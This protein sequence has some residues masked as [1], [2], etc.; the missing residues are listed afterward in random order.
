MKNKLTKKL[1]SAVLS[2]AMLLSLVP[3]ASLTAWADNAAVTYLDADGN[4][5][6][7]TE[8]TVFDSSM[9]MI[10]EAGWYVV[11]ENVPISGEMYISADVNLILCD[12]ATL[13]VT[14]ETYGG[15]VNG[16]KNLTIYAQSTG[17]DM[18]G[19]SVTN[20]QSYGYALDFSDG[21]IIINGGKISATGGIS[22]YNGD[23][24]I[25]GG[26]VTAAG[27]YTNGICASTNNNLTINGGTVTVST[28]DNS[29]GGIE[30][31]GNVIVNGG[32]VSAIG[33][34]NS[35][36]CSTGVTVS[37]GALTVATTM[38]GTYGIN[39]ENKGDVT[40]SGGELTASAP[41][42][43]IAYANV[44]NAVPG[45][46]WTD[47][48]GTSGETEIAVSTTGQD[49]SAYKKVVIGTPAPEPVSYKNAAYD[50][51]TNTVTY[52]DATCD[53]YTAVAATTTEWGASG[54]TS[55]YVVNDTVEITSSITVSGTVN[56]ILCDGAS[57]T[58]S[59]GVNAS[60]ATLNIYGQSAGTGALIANAANGSDGDDDS[61]GG[62]G[63]TA[64][65]CGTL[66]VNGAAVTATGGNG[67]YG[68]NGGN[69]G[70]GISGNVTVNGGTVTATGGN[71]GSGFYAGNGGSGISGNATVNN[72]TVT[73]TGG[74]GG[75][76]HQFGSNGSDG[77]AVT[78]NITATGTGATVQESDNN[79]DWSYVSG[80]SSDKRF[81]HGEATA[82]APVSYKNAAYDSATNTVTYTDATCD[83]YT[84]VAADTTTF[85]DGKWYVVN[86]NVTVNGSITVNG[87]ANLILADGY[88]LTVTK[89]V[90][91]TDPSS[92][93]IFGQENGAGTLTATGG[94]DAAG[95]GGINDK[96]GPITINGGTVN[97]T[98][99]DDG[100]AGIG[101]SDGNSCGDIT[102]NGGTVNASASGSSNIY[103]IGDAGWGSN[104]DGTIAI[105]GGTV[106]VN[107]GEYAYGIGYC[108]N[109]TINITGGVV[110]V[111]K[112]K[113]WATGFKGGNL[114]V[115][116]GEVYAAGSVAVYS[117]ANFTGGTFIAESLRDN[118]PAIQSAT[119]SIA[120]GLKVLLG[121][122]EANAVEVEPSFID[123]SSSE[124]WNANPKWIKI[125]HTPEPEPTVTWYAATENIQIGEDNNQS[126]PYDASYTK[127]AITVSATSAEGHTYID[128]T[129]FSEAFM[130]SLS[131]FVFT[132]SVANFSKIKLVF[133]DLSIVSYNKFIDSEYN[134]DTHWSS[135]LDSKT[136]TWEGDSNSVGLYAYDVSG[137]LDRIEF[138]YEVPAAVSF[139]K[140]TDADQIAVDN[141]G[142]CT[143]DEAK[144]WVY[145]NWDS[146]T[147]GVSS[148]TYIEIVYIVNGSARML[149]FFTYE[150]S[151]KDEFKALTQ[152]DFD[153]DLATIKE[154]YTSGSDV[155]YVCSKAAPTAVSFT[156]VTDVN[157]IT[158]DN[159]G[160]CT[161]DDA[162]AWA[163][164]NWNTVASTTAE[165]FW[166]AYYD[167]A[168]LKAFNFYL[169]L[170][171]D[172]FETMSASAATA[173]GID[174][175]TLCYNFSDDVW[176]C[177]PA[178]AP[179][180]VHSLTPHAAADA[181]CTTAGNS[182]YWSCSCGKYFSDENGETEIAENSWVIPAPGHNYEGV[183]Y[184]SD[185]TYHWK[186]CSR[187][188]EESA[189]EDHIW[190]S[191]L[192][193]WGDNNSTVTASHGCTVCGKQ[194]SET[195]DTTS[196]VTAAATCTTKELSTFTAIFT[197]P[198]FTTQT[199]EGVETGLALGHN[200]S[201]VGL[202]ETIIAT[203]SHDG[204]EYHTNGVTLTIAAPALTVY[205]GAESAAATL[206]GLDAFN[207]AT[208]LS[209][210]ENAI[211]YYNTKIEGME[212]LKDGL[213]LLSP[214][215]AGTYWAEIEI[216][217]AT[218]YVVYTIAKTDPIATAPT[219]VEA[220]Y[221]D[222]LSDVTLTNAAGNTAGTWSWEDDPMTSVGNAG[223]NVF[224]AKF[225]PDDTDNYNVI[226]HVQ[227]TVTVSKATPA[228]TVPTGLNATY[229]DTLSSVALPDGWEWEDEGTTPVGTAG[230]N[231]FKAKF[232][233]D[234]TDNFNAVEHVDVT[235]TVGKAGST[236]ASVA[237]NE[238]TF[239][240][241]TK[242]LLTVTGEA[243]GGTM[244]YALGTAT[245][246]GT[247]GDSI[248]EATAADTYYVWY[249]VA[250]DANHN[251]TDAVCVTVVVAHDEALDAVIAAIDAIGPVT[252][253]LADQKAKIDAARAGYE[254]LTPAQQALVTN[255]ATLVA[256]EADYKA[257]FVFDANTQITISGVEKYGETLTAT[258]IDV[259]AF[260]TDAVV[261][262]YN[263]DG[264]LLGTGATYTLT[265]A[266][267]GK[268]VR[269]ELYSA[270]AEDTVTSDFTGL[271]GKGVIK[272]YTLPTAAHVT[273]PQT[274]AEAT[275]TG[276]DTGDIEGVWAW[277]TPDAQPTSAQSGSSFELTFTPTGTYA[278]LYEGFTTRL[279]VVVDPAPFEP[280]SIEDTASGLTFD[281]EFAQNVEVE[282]TD[283]VYSQSA[284][285]ALLRASKKDDSGMTKLV[286]LK[287]IAFTIDGEA[288]DEAYNG[289]V[290]VTSYVGAKLAGQTVSVWFFIDGAPVNYVGT[291]GYDGV[292]VIENVAL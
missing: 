48:A 127:D 265:A 163:L 153:A 180:H 109:G 147:D 135:D 46:G 96:S 207:A 199:K 85:E 112:D 84:A 248:P 204:C 167:G 194:V 187:C 93:T 277:A 162:K 184:S 238:W 176:L 192:Y 254:D 172:K 231:V 132:N 210:S 27:V 17:E 98:G 206:E 261:R 58:A 108:G 38:S 205:G 201:Y 126:N 161:F 116:G 151:D 236:A 25:N 209:I 139:V 51:A 89:G 279:A 175:L 52:T 44:K 60:G 24:T 10:E 223:N 171:K 260:I 45:T 197:K 195:V 115:S 18:G 230:S 177:T 43:G 174:D 32:T 228:Y 232:T 40:I 144:A 258:A 218:A 249:K 244:K 125:Y 13:T 110:N 156:K 142:E 119:V 8:Y 107:P 16:Y 203:C 262:W 196:M 5:Q 246:P 137:T 283:I 250:G 113:V 86:S 141:I 77:K 157:D 245:A 114:N 216:Q 128:G 36:L 280:Q 20:Q 173:V 29:H 181:G 122:D 70:S 169:E 79:I 168:D 106:N 185:E 88:T 178:A 243:A 272:N 211:Q 215:G 100:G 23:I 190:G 256:A 274:L 267:I 286:L 104:G 242:P 159:I 120:S 55:W 224:Q 290:T 252:E 165:S 94:S 150:F 3:A 83:D 237:A 49:L 73:A 145:D 35:A 160:A 220:T 64:I 130:A 225:T 247:F 154:Y 289:A 71:G 2:V 63:S 155:V 42:G 166:F 92:L 22:I 268:S 278:D 253:V 75:Q 21:S 123:Y 239:D 81:I 287:T 57:L 78:G 149:A 240:G 257:L 217:N 193:V 191:T 164:A 183:P 76:G 12:R 39:C 117:N 269:A 97:A 134:D 65:T 34:Y 235:V 31:G 140:V 208:G 6:T 234:D 143:F 259:P 188:N 59:A 189:R 7:C 87:A 198:G 270:E 200:F 284:Y 275:L 62:A 121:S 133:T 219:G 105:H 276:G 138:T 291:V 82:S 233:P 54:T 136:V 124:Y 266:E 56:L 241:A 47:V 1:L 179:A 111:N 285:L 41:G 292:L 152:S 28:T 4:E 99:D 214:A 227:V 255:Y 15:A 102:I 226:E 158:A 222:T 103:G 74:V 30:M 148:T 182:A 68:F 50:S 90:A 273:Y 186:V 170:G 281:A 53:D 229:G 67:G 129:R 11:K 202:N 263:E 72:G 91:V 26:N 271:I 131:G 282:L 19:L 212:I 251:D 80:G 14:A 264:D 61:N 101:A 33:G 118:N 69:G 9:T 146:V 213:P 95:I 288:A 37:G 221:G 66:S